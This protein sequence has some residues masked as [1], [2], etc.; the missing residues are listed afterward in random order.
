VKLLFLTEFFPRDNRLVFTG[1]VE[2]RTYYI[3][4]LAKKDFKVAV[5]ANP[6]RRVAATSFSIFPRF[7]YQGVALVKALTANFDLIEGSNV[8]S[9]LPA[10]LAGK[11]KRKPAVAWVP[12]VLGRDWF[13]FGPIVGWL[14]YWQEKLSLHLP[15]DKII[16]LSQITKDKLISRGVPDSKISV[17][18]GGVDLNEFKFSAPD[19]KK[20]TIICVARLVATKRI[21]DLIKALEIINSRS[22]VAPA[23][24]SG[25]ETQ[26]TI[27]GAGPQ[28]DTLVNLAR[29]IGVFEKITWLEGLSRRELIKELKQ[30]TVF[31]LPSVVEGFGLVTV[32]GMTAGLPAVI[33]DIPVN[34]ETCQNDQGALFFK[35]QNPRDLAIKLNQLLTNPSLYQRKQK[36]AKKLATQYS[37]DKIYAQTKKIYLETSPQGLTLRK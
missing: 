35:P 7:L 25:K 15:W 27:I 22:G 9:Y 29:K 1:G 30:A 23:A 6:F 32:E 4:T 19:R 31:C 8:T 16:A 5:I 26:L 33:A 20:N 17:V 2:S 24:H 13:R 37:W 18:H 3:A 36:E 21:E 10:F 34:R 28:K 11:L 12:D 14:G